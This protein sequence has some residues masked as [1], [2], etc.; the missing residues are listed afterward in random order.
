MA[1][2]L[3]QNGR[4]GIR[5]H[6]STQPLFDNEFHY[7]NG[8]A[9]IPLD[10]NG[11]YAVAAFLIEICFISP[12]RRAKEVDEQLAAAENAVSIER[13]EFE[14]QIATLRSEL[15]QRA[16]RRKMADRLAHAME[17]GRKF[18]YQYKNCFGVLGPSDEEINGWTRNEV[19][20]ISTELGMAY[21]A[22]YNA[23][24]ESVNP[25]SAVGVPGHMI[26]HYALLTA[27]IRVLEDFIKELAPLS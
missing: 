10:T 6:G 14:K 13:S 25:I 27:R 23:A 17:K 24:E 19:N 12:Y 22:R 11:R 20:P 26:E 21:V 7:E 1:R 3:L 2:C 4:G 8:R 5:T 18:A 16:A 15:D 9:E